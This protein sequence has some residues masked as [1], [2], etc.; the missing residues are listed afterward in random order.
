MSLL[1]PR[2]VSTDVNPTVAVFCLRAILGRCCCARVDESAAVALRPLARHGLSKGRVNFG[3]VKEK[4]SFRVLGSGVELKGL[5]DDSCDDNGSGGDLQSCLSADVCFDRRLPQVHGMQNIDHHSD[6]H[7]DKR[8]N[9]APLMD[10]V[11]QKSLFVATLLFSLGGT[12]S[13]KCITY[14]SVGIE[15]DQNIVCISFFSL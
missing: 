9:K 8:K 4:Q 5:F 6:Y 14:S 3:A 10:F 2:P 13:I 12:Q 11:Q 15:L 1:D 7:T